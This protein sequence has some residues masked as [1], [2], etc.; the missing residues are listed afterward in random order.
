MLDI[1]NKFSLSQ[2]MSWA[3]P[4]SFVGAVAIPSLA[5]LY[6]VLDTLFGQVEIV[7]KPEVPAV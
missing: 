7:D 1:G 4:Q 2:W 3:L 5:I 6:W